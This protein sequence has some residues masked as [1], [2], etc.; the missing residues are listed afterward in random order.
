MMKCEE[1]VE[2][3]R[4]IRNFET[5]LQSFKKFLQVKGHFWVCKSITKSPKLVTISTD[6]SS[7]DKTCERRRRWGF[8]TFKLIILF[9]F[10][11]NQNQNTV[12]VTADFAKRNIAATEVAEK[13][14]VWFIEETGKRH[15]NRWGPQT[16]CFPILPLSWH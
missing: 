11:C 12:F 3:E 6:I 9:Y 2:T 7:L 1:R 4:G 8:T 16:F 5:N 15:W 14:L 10:W 13:Y